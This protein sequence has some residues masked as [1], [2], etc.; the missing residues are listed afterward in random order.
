MCFESNVHCGRVELPSPP[1]KMASTNWTNSTHA[2]YSPL[3]TGL[4]RT[5]THGLFGSAEWARTI[6]HRLNRPGLY[7]LSYCGIFLVLPVGLEPTASYLQG[8]YSTNWVKV[9]KLEQ[10]IRLELMTSTWKDD[11]FPTTP[12]L[13]KSLVGPLGVEPRMFTTKGAD[14]QSADAHAIASKTPFKS[15]E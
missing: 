14:L 4:R 5:H 8:R 3:R 15:P 11:M 6:D 1:D 9:A 7:Q 2:L 10:R 12:T 13:L